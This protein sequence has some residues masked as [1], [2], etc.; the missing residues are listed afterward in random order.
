VVQKF[1]VVVVVGGGGWW[2]VCKPI[3]VL[4]FDQAEQFVRCEQTYFVE[5]VDTLKKQ[6]GLSRA[7]LKIS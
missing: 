2:V 4:S 7:T 3:S 1:V 5:I 6:A